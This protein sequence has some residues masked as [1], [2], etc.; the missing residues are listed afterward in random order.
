MKP[1]GTRHSAAGLIRRLTALL[2]AGWLSASLCRAAAVEGDED[3]TALND[4]LRQLIVGAVDAEGVLPPAATNAIM[5]SAP[6]RRPTARSAPPGPLLVYRRSTDTNEMP[7]L[8][9]YLEEHPGDATAWR[10]LG[11]QHFRL[12]EYAAA[13]AAYRYA[14]DLAGDDPFTINNYAATLVA[15]QQLEPAREIL[16]AELMRRANN[17]FARFNLACVEARE[18]RADEA[19]R[20]LLTIEGARW[21]VLLLHLSDPDLDALRHLPA[22]I[23]LRE[24]L[25]KQ[26]PPDAR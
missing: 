2:A 10:Q 20:L 14:L 19:M 4:P 11:D 26:R 18:G 25:E 21:P 3:P 6:E 15:Q 22:F 23:T 9:K 5:A 12:Q 13:A 24:R 8:K 16:R 1:R 17:Q 7:R